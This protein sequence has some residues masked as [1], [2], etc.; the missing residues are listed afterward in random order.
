MYFHLSPVRVSLGQRLGTL[1]SSLQLARLS[2]VTCRAGTREIKYCA[3]AE[4]ALVGGA[5]IATA[6]NFWQWHA[7]HTHVYG[8]KIFTK[9]LIF[10]Q[11]FFWVIL[12]G[13]IF[14][15]ILLKT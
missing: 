8:G 12:W 5:G 2:N 7:R 10:E 9:I 15:K 6:G 13:K 11:D 3:L 14:V 1:A 4:V